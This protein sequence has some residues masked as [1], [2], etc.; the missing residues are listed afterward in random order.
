[1]AHGP[2]CLRQKSADVPF[3]SWI[4]IDAATQ[5]TFRI[6]SGDPAWETSD[7]GSFQQANCRFDISA[8][9]GTDFRFVLRISGG[10]LEAQG[11]DSADGLIRFIGSK[12]ADIVEGVISRGVRGDQQILW[13][14]DGV[15]VG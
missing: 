5:E 8:E 4:F 3:Y 9:D 14:S 15:S 13:E 7:D 2:G 11:I 10:V 1:M 6:R 12:G